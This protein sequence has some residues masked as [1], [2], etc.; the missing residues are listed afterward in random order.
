M[1]DIREEQ[2]KHL[3]KSVFSWLQEFL[4]AFSEKSVESENLPQGLVKAKLIA[5]PKPGKDLSCPE[6]YQF[7]SLLLKEQYFRIW[8]QCSARDDSGLSG[9]QIWEIYNRPSPGSH[10]TLKK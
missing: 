7:I 3:G 2:L 6:S 1:D 8:P 9:L 4:S 5:L 10:L